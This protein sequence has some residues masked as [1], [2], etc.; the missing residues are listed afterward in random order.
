MFNTWQSSIKKLRNQ[1]LSAQEFVE[2]TERKTLYYSTPFITI[3]N[4]DSPNVL[5]TKD[6]DDVYFPVFTTMTGLKAYMTAIGC[7]E[8]IVIKGDLKTVMMS[9]D[10]HPMLREWG[11]V[12]NPQ[13]SRA[14]EIPPQTRP[15][16]KCLR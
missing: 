13:S 1:T 12:V 9:L 3:E 6:S 4:S 11:I 8:H 15:R 2:K 16:P 14:A 7:A 5:Q 10:M